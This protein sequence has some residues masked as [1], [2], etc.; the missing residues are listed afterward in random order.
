VLRQLHHA[1][2]DDVQGGLLFPHVVDGALEGTLLDAL[3]EFREFE[4][5]GQECGRL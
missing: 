3:K 5:G 2:L 1:V 4:V